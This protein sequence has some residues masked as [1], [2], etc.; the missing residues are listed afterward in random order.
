MNN[1]KYI[2]LWHPR[3][4]IYAPQLAVPTTIYNFQYARHQQYIREIGLNQRR[5]E[6]GEPG[7]E[8]WEGLDRTASKS[9]TSS[10]IPNTTVNDGRLNE[11]KLLK[12][13]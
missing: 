4:P 11:E 1:A 9:Q 6:T 8:C 5:E 13:T 12:A 10:L 2:T 3:I 7:P